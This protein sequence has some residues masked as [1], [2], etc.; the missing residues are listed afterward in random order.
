MIA[1]HVNSVVPYATRVRP[2]NENQFQTLMEFQ[3]RMLTNV[4]PTIQKKAEVLS[5]TIFE[6]PL[7][8][9]ADHFYALVKTYMDKA[10]R[11]YNL[12]NNNEH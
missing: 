8:M 11:P 12:F 4:M 6:N 7:H 9:K 2:L 3:E 5:K 10:L 1:D